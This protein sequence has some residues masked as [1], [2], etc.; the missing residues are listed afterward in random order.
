MVCAC[1][2]A[3]PATRNLNAS[4]RRA[5]GAARFTPGSNP[6]V[7]SMPTRSV[8]AFLIFLAVF[9][10]ITWINCCRKTAFM[11]PGH[12]SAPRVP[13]SRCSKRPHAWY[14]VPNSVRCWCSDIPMPSELLTTSWRSSRTGQSAWKVSTITLSV[15]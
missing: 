5:A 1:V 14:T 7:I 10:A 13:V 6:C 15:T 8:H 3:R 11:S 9:R 4:S 12:W 2:W